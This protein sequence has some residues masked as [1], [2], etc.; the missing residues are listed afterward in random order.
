M[1]SASTHRNP[2]LGER[3]CKHTVEL[4]WCFHFNRREVR[5]DDLLARCL[6]DGKVDVL[7]LDQVIHLLLVQLKIR[8]RELRSTCA[9]EGR[10]K[11]ARL[12]REESEHAPLDR[13]LT[14][15]TEAER[16]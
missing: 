12:A 5:N 14:G 2:T 7:L 11:W 4:V 6:T 10:L 15:S 1:A 3:V 16:T 13:T 8:H 9:R